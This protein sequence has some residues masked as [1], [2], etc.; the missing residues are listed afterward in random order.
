LADYP[1]PFLE[2]EP[3]DPKTGA[4]PLLVLLHGRDAFA[5]TIF[6]V[7]HLLPASFHVISIRATYKSPRE[8]FEWFKPYDYDH[9]IES[10]SEEHYSESVALTTEMIRKLTNEKPIDKYN[11]FL[12]GFSQGAAMCH[13]LS[14]GEELPIK[15]VVPMSGFFPRPIEKWTTINTK[16]QFLISH[17]TEDKV[18]GKEESIYA[19][20]FLHSKGISAEYY[21]YKGRHK[22]TLPLLSYISK[23]LLKE[24][25]TYKK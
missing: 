25:G 1:L 10:F 16:P 24:A 8:G 12:L 3:R 23:W 7:E 5:E 21:E 19:F 14:L 13:F 20:N 4:P 22:M 2:R 6:S 15:G 11:I 17:G 18:L 9:P